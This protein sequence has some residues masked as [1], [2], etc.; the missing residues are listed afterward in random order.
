MNVFF[1]VDY[2]LISDYGDL[3]PWVREVFQQLRLD[4][5]VIYVWSG[6][7]IRWPVV[8]RHGLTP[9]VANCYQKPLEDHHA[10]L[11]G[12]GVDVPPDFCV[13]D[14]QEIIDAFGGAVVRPYYWRNTLDYEM[15]RIYALVSS[16]Q[17]KP[18]E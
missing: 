17:P 6:V 18:R 1:D 7:G 10:R 15:H 9:F 16:Y 12:L 5:H 2:T 14:Y 4:G 3:R 13:D 8:Q 11:K